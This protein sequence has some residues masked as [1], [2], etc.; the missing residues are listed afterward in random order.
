MTA[1]PVL[2]SFRRCPYAMRARLAL[3]IS[4][5]RCELREVALRDK[6]E[7]LRTASAKATVPVLIDEAGCVIDESLD[8]MLWALRRND[9][10]QWLA[11]ADGDL[12]QMLALIA[13]CDGEFKTHLDR[14]KYPQ[15]YAGAVREAHRDAGGGFAGELN[16]RLSTREHLFGTQASLAD[17]AIVPFVRQFAGTDTAWF[18]AQPWSPLQR[19]LQRFLE[20]PI[21]RHVMMKFVP[22]QSGTAGILFPQAS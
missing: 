13:R 5:V 6:P 19:W 18:A 14:Y 9:P 16:A 17:M 12:D 7:A 4:A 3:A 2:Y 1:I 10:A 11:P 20:S 21:Y 22:W 15:R 8:I